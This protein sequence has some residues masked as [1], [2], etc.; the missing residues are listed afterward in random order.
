MVYSEA[1]MK[2][3]QSKSLYLIFGLVI[4]VLLALI[5]YFAYQLISP[6]DT[7]TNSNTNVNATANSNKNSN[8][9]KNSNKNNSNV[10][11][12]TNSN[13]NTNEG[14]VEPTNSNRNKNSNTNSTNDEDA[15]EDTDKDSEEVVA[16]EGE[17]V[18][19]LY[20]AKD[21]AACGEVSAVQRAVTPAED[22][23]GQIMLADLAGP[24]SDE[25]G[26]TNAAAGVRLRW[27]EYTSEGSKVYVNEAYDE[28]SDCDKETAAA[29]L[30]QTANV[31]FEVGAKNDGEVIVGYPEGQDPNEDGDDTNSNTNEDEE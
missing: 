17:E 15:D 1:M 18:I 10:N 5:G 19:T 11:G 25:D 3:Q 27:V 23:Y 20:F 16:G 9:N 4:V 12:N 2:N 28:L 29:Q 21:N 22:F 13:S 8:A 24:T 6:G 14:L 31:M 30:I 26:Y 7:E